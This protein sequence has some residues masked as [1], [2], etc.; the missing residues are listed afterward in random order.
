MREIARPAS[1][2]GNEAPE[3]RVASTVLV[4]DRSG[5]TTFVIAVSSSEPPGDDPRP[6]QYTAVRAALFAI[7]REQT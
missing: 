2:G 6:H 7:V 1:Q 5:T 4:R 3:S